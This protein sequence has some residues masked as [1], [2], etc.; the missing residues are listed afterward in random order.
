MSLQVLS[1][2]GPCGTSTLPIAGV[3]TYYVKLEEE[4]LRYEGPKISGRYQDRKM[5]PQS[6]R[7]ISICTRPGV[8]SSR[9]EAVS[10]ASERSPPV[11]EV[12]ERTRP[13]IVGGSGVGT[14][15]CTHQACARDQAVDHQW[16][17]ADCLA[18]AKSTSTS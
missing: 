1:G 6:M 17:A 10:L 5:V 2:A 13:H 3:L 9:M 18:L 8:S 4:K 11:D 12:K 15:Q 14:A 16:T 7:I